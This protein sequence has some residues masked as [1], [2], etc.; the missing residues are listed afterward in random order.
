ME[1]DAQNVMNDLTLSLA[2]ISSQQKQMEEAKVAEK[3]KQDV[4][5]LSFDSDLARKKRQ[6]EQTHEIE[7]QNNERAIVMLEA[8][9]K[10]IVSKFQAFAPS[11]GESLMALSNNETLAKVA[12]ALSVQNL[13]GGKTALDVIVGIFKGTPLQAIMEGVVRKAT[14]PLPGN[15][16]TGR[17]P[18]AG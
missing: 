9:A 12:E 8:E 6:A 5:D 4:S 15:G 3:A 10:A 1:I 14:A 7:V 2:K 18:I 13:I 16:D 17:R 11:M